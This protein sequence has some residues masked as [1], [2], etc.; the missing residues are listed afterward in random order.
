MRRN[1]YNRKISFIDG[2]KFDSRAEGTLYQY[3]KLL[4]D[5]KEISDL[6]CQV[7]VYLTDAR[8]LYKPDFKFVRDGKEIYAEMKGIETSSWRIKRRLW[9]HYGP[10]TLEVWNHSKSRGCVL[11]ETIEPV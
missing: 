7:S 1:K 10:S 9:M 8:I 2:R 6:Q 11:K 3:L 5:A 4:V